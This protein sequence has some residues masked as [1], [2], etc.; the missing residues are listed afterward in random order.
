MLLG[1]LGS[2]QP[3]Y[4]QVIEQKGGKT[5]DT[6]SGETPSACNRCYN[7]SRHLAPRE[8]PMMSVLAR[9]WWAFVIRGV[10]AILFGLVALFVPGAAM[11][12]LVLV[13]AVYAAA[14]GVFAIVSAVR[15]AKEG[16]RWMW[17]ALEGVVDIIAAAVAVAMPG[18]TVIVFVTLLAIWAIVT[19]AFMLAA[20]F[21][22]DADHGRWWLVLGS[23]ASLAYGVLLL[24]APTI[25]AVVLTWWIG[26]Y[27][28]VFGIS[29]L[30]AAFHLRARLK[31]SPLAR[32]A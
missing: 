4:F 25:G 6:V 3:P 24:I 7:R 10:L 32:A 26:A 8:P 21:K 5:S 15:A 23:M 30:V 29:L 1:A 31:A 12:S 28:I 17:F 19:G 20:A 27:A 2:V 9:N 14:D 22:L 11:L 18:L 13:F 16:E